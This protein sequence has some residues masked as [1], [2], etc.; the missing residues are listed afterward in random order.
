MLK[1]AM[2]VR[3]GLL[4][5]LLGVAAPV[6]AQETPAPKAKPE[7]PAA[8]DKKPEADKEEADKS[9][10]SE[11][12]PKADAKQEAPATET[13]KEATPP[14]PGFDFGKLKA[15]GLVVADPVTLADAYSEKYDIEIKAPFQIAVPRSEEFIRLALYPNDLEGGF[16]KITFATKEKAFLENIQFTDLTVEEGPLEKRQQQLAAVMKTKGWEQVVKGF[17]ENKIDSIRAVKIGDEDAVELVGRYID[18]DNGVIVSRLLAIF[19]EG[20]TQ[21]V[22]SVS[23]IAAQ[24]VP[25]TQ[26]EHLENTISGE[27][28]KSFEFVE[29][30]KEPTEK[31][32]EPKE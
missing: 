18:K 6:A 29:A 20:E 11:S 15:E 16:L 8:A 27:I 25:V 12:T 10:P 28:M 23:N 2:I 3:F 13:A 30:P 31:P 4:C 14:Q 9:D 5:A 17:G 26:L 21:G 32:E 24:R 1:P 7:M 22:F 19:R